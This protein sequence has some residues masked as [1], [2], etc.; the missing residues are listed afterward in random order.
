M[1]SLALFLVL[2]IGTGTASAAPAHDFVVAEWN[3][4]KSAV[5]TPAMAAAVD[6]GYCIA[7][8][9]GTRITLYCDIK[10]QST[11]WVC[12]SG[13]TIEIPL[14]PGRWAPSGTR[15]QYYGYQLTA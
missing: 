9:S 13:V 8:R 2:P 3:T 6:R 5:R 10:V 7:V 15:L 1:V 14:P 11:L 12:C 4:A